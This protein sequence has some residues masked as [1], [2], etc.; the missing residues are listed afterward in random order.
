VPPPKALEAFTG[1]LEDLELIELDDK[2]CWAVTLL[3]Q[4]MLA[5][6]RGQLH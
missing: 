1:F 6:W 5:E 3:G 2:G 4:S